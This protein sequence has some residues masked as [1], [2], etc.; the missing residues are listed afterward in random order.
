M[1]VRR[2]LRDDRHV[3][4]T[5]YIG[6][7]DLFYE[8]VDVHYR[9]SNE[10][11]SI[12]NATL[13]AHGKG[14]KVFRQGVWSHVS[15]PTGNDRNLPAQGW[16]IH[17]SATGANC[18]ELLTKV[19]AMV[20]D[21]D[22]RFK[23]ANDTNTLKMM[24]SKRWARGGSGKFI[25]IYPP[26]DEVFHSFIELLHS[27]VK[28]DDGSYILSDN[29]YKDCRCLYYR[30][31]G[32]L[33]TQRLDFM[34]RLVPVLTSPDGEEI[35]DIRRPYFEV[36]SWV[37]D[38]FPIED[39]DQTEMTL[40]DGRFIVESAL[41]FSNTG[42][43]YLAVDTTTGNKVVIKEARPFVELHGKDR[44]AISRLKQEEKILRILGGLGITP[45]VITTFSDWENFYL[46]EEY[47][48]ATDIRAIMLM[49]SPL[50]R[51]SP[52]IEDG[53]NFYTIYKRIFIS[54]L[55][56]IDKAHAA[57]VVIADL[58]APN[59]L[60]DKETYTVKIIDLEAGFQP[61][62]DDAT[63]IYTPGFR[64]MAKGRKKTNDYDDDLYAAAA[65]MLYCM[66][67]IV[68]V[69]YLRDDL[70]TKVLPVVLSDIGWEKTPVHEIILGLS[71]GT[72]TCARACALF[73]S[74]ATFEQP[75]A[76]RST[77]N[78][79]TPSEGYRELAEF[80]LN[81]YR[82]DKEY[83]LFP[84]DPFARHTNTLGLGFGA[85]GI[86][87]SLMQSGFEVAPAAHERFAKELADA[88]GDRLAPGLLT[89]SAGIAFA[90]FG[91]GD[92]E[93]A[94]RF[95]GY[96]NTSPLLHSH[97][98]L[99]YGMAGVGMANLVAYRR[100]GK[101]KYL[102]MAIDLAEGLVREGIDDGNGIHWKD[103][104]SVR[105]GF[106]YGQSGVA[107]FFLRLSQI[108]G[109]DSWKTFGQ[110]ALNYD[111]SFG[112]E[113]E[114]GTITF[115]CSP[116]EESTFEQYIEQGSAG[117]AKVA[118][119]YGRWREADRI[120][121]DVHRKYAGFPGLLYGLSGFIDVLVD[122]YRFSG[123]D[124]YLHMTRRPLEGLVDLYFIKQVHG[125]ATP[126]DNL[127]RVS[128]DYATGVA[129]VMRTLYRLAHLTADDFSLDELDRIHTTTAKH[130]TACLRPS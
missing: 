70:F 41:G 93:A 75:L 49:H 30:Y 116:E 26:T 103:K 57:G 39:T 118:I 51:P 67:P 86:V 25:T 125:H 114:G 9:P 106:G 53:A 98:S 122:A 1:R 81:S 95:L 12:V 42:G 124:K 45:E 108:M 19:V 128:C 91:I 115:G 76:D 71:M 92:N 15:P 28:D 109:V 44:D 35:P 38:P 107:L 80:V 11:S 56:S 110:K 112:R 121:A 78:A 58:S 10:F 61:S 117:I 83:T 77:T 99:Y 50:L 130:S 82:L 33:Q 105:I 21:H 20:L 54:L 29:R 72:M 43:V 97:H 32:M 104:E 60:I 2:S 87:Y 69:A 6:I 3:D 31:G 65:L 123:D 47:F 14:W 18:I 68:A 73:E 64:S 27:V 48:D 55:G 74:P 120:L 59:L 24:T 46:A 52:I 66:F 94:E 84:V 127:F 36:P 13:D 89:G 23:F 63:D 16:K 102:E 4:K 101:A 40:N 37:T 22:I 126:G 96:A 85:S 100:T 8:A 34:G 88:R 119:R 17:V 79:F 5:F 129:G 7:D 90:L 113:R 62:I 111:L